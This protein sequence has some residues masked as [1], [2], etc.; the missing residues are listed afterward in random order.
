[1]THPFNRRDALRLGAFGIAASGLASVLGR[2]AYAAC[3]PVPTD[4]AKTLFIFLRGGNDAANTV[5][6]RED[7]TYSATYRANGTYIASGIPLGN[8]FA[9]LHPA[10]TPLQEVYDQHGVVFLH[11][12]GN[13]NR[14][15]SHF[16]DQQF[17]ETAEPGN[18]LAQEGWVSR[19]A[20]F[21][22]PSSVGFRAVSV[23]DRV[24]RLIRTED[25]TRVLA[26]VRQIRDSSGL[27]YTLDSPGTTGT[28]LDDKLRGSSPSSSFPTGQGL[29]GH[30]DSPPGSR[31]HDALIRA[32]G[33]Q[34]LES[35]QAISALAPYVPQNGADYPTGPTPEN[36]LGSSGFIYSFLAQLQ[37]AVQLLKQTT[38]RIAC[39]EMGGFDTHKD[40][41]G[42]TGFHAD[43]LEGLAYGL[44]SV[45]RDMLDF[46]LL[47]VTMS[48]FGRTSADNTSKGTDHGDAGVMLAMSKKL[49]LRAVGE[50]LSGVYNCDPTTWADGDMFSSGPPVQG[51]PG[52]YIGMLT[53]Y[54]AVIA[55]G[56]RKHH[57]LST[58]EVD[59]VI[60]G[61]STLGLA[62]LGYHKS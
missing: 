49:E 37:D 31:K 9:E 1:M 5:I 39:V 42:A 34:M 55:E 26:H 54:R 35:E 32:M 12:V 27:V 50:T 59:A 21:V 62:E 19:L 15:G 33:M 46:D 40:Q 17:W 18:L 47:A 56:L 28:P 13:P 57:Q 10:M 16:T 36:G 30:Y 38:A 45:W 48:E 53:D 43:L 41:G 2:P 58:A 51:Q 29:R 4:T 52:S 22:A 7:D 23:S 14:S 6:P 3:R 61:Y 8:G 25:P 11:R 60:P 44:R 20:P 24:Q